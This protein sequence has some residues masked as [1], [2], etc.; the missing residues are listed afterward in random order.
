VGLNLKCNKVGKCRY[1]ILYY[2]WSLVKFVNK[3]LCVEHISRVRCICFPFIA[4]SVEM[5]PVTL[6]QMNQHDI[7][8][9]NMMQK[10][11]IFSLFSLIL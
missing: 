5:E 3:S 10:L 6:Y 7:N 11:K 8:T 1:E 4:H 9:Q 2:D